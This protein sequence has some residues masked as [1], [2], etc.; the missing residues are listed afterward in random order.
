MASF[1]VVGFVYLV[2]GFNVFMPSDMKW[3]YPHYHPT[4][5]MS[6]LGIVNAPIPCK[7]DMA[8]QLEMVQKVALV[9]SIKEHATLPTGQ[10]IALDEVIA[11][12]VQFGNPVLM[13]RWYFAPEGTEGFPQLGGIA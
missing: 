5:R 12:V 8:E 7:S 13:W 3:G 1:G 2:I 11:K 4:F 9:P 10:D 6:I